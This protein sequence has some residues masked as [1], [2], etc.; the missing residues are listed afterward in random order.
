[1]RFQGISRMDRII[2]YENHSLAS[3]VNSKVLAEDRIYVI[4][5]I[6]LP[7]TR[8]GYYNDQLFHN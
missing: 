4:T 7:T 1:M 5:P 3:C 2:G 6:S 8:T